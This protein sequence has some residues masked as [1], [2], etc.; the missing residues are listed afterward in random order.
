MIVHWYLQDVAHTG[1]IHL[2]EG[3]TGV[4]RSKR[5]AEALKQPQNLFSSGFGNRDMVL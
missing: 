3:E 4:K 5:A 1:F 2:L